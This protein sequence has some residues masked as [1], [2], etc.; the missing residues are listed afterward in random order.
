VRRGNGAI[1]QR[2]RRT[3]IPVLLVLHASVLAAQASITGVVREDSTGRPL[4]GAEVSVDAL[5]RLTLTDE[6][7]R[8][9][10]RNLPP[11][12]L[13]VRVRLLG[14]RAAERTERL[15]A[16]DALTLD[17]R[18]VRTPVQLDTLAVIEPENHKP[19]MGLAGFEERKRRGFGKFIDSTQLRES[20]TRR[21]EDVLREVRGVQILT[22]PNC[23]PRQS[24]T[25]EPN[26]QKRV[27]AVG[28]CPMQITID[29]S[30]IYHAHPGTPDW[31]QTFDLNEIQVSTLVA[32]E[33]YRN[34]SEV[35]IAY[36]A[37]GSACGLILFWTTHR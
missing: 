31:P 13:L 19:S 16:G 25:C 10:L 28:T 7:G 32:I 9:V 37:P 6:N 18:L 35:P 26:Q 12:P 30:V 29:G 8:F 15:V 21:V 11:G 4:A 17:V 36:G 22:P 3:A 34:S 14:Y 5:V 2:V 33:V 24:R 27:A 23:A 20:D 1:F